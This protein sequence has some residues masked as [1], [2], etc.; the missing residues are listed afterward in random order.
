LYRLPQIPDGELAGSKTSLIGHAV[1]V[2]ATKK[3]T[4]KFLLDCRR[5]RKKRE[6][7][8]TV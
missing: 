5:V 1:Q 8:K 3:K 4:F 6:N 2:Y 7:D